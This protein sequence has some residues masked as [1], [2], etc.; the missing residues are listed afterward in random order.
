MKLDRRQ[1]NKAIGSIAFAGLAASMAGCSPSVAREKL[2][3]YGPLIKDPDGLFDLPKGFSYKVI[4]K[5][6]DK[7][8]DGWTVPDRADGMG[9]FALNGSEVALVRNHELKIG[10][11]GEGAFGETIP[12][13]VEVYDTND[14]GEIMAGGT[15]TI[16]YDVVSGERVREYVSL[17]GTIRNCSGGVTPWGSWL[18]CEEDVTNAGNGAH[19]DHG[20]VFEVPADAEGVVS[21]VPLKEM[22]RFNHEAAAVDPRTG[23]VYLTEDRD[24]SL[25]YRFIPK[26]KG[27]LSEGGKLQALALK[28]AKGMET[29]NWN[30]KNLTVGVWEAS[31]WVDLDN[32]ESPEDDLRY[33]GQ[34]KG[35]ATFARGEG[36]HWGDGELYFCCTS[37]GAEG[38]GQIMRYK[39]SEHEGESGE[40]DKPGQLQLFLESRTSE[41]FNFGDNLTVAPN[42]H[43]IV[44]ED[45]Y[46]LVVDNHL[47]GVTPEGKL[48]DFAKLQSQTELAG[49]CFSPDGST[50]F[51]NVYSPAKTLAITGPWADFKNA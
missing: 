15:T 45:Q 6:G 24:N 7:M 46:S 20:Y 22:G 4:S 30:D 34:E 8:S 50:L 37:G 2:Q 39:P 3:A 5:L 32:P 35:A 11:T 42:G 10:H 19:K 14:D 28:K 49:A 43:L 17:A 40:A 26:V 16:V 27:K 12:E 31:E 38:Y 18:T 48:Y 36:I 25:F 41:E 13:G 23:I 44:C 29:H 47:R 51:V 9:C 21:P 33:R 1:F